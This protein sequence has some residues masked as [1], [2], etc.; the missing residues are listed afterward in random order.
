MVEVLHYLTI[1]TLFMGL[2]FVQGGTKGFGLGKIVFWVFIGP[3]MFSA[4]SE[5]QLISSAIGYVGG[6]WY[7]RSSPVYFLESFVYRL[8]ERWKQKF[9]S[10]SDGSPEFEQRD[11][12]SQQHEQARKRSEEAAKERQRQSKEDQ[13]SSNTQDNSD[14]SGQYSRTEAEYEEMKK[15]ARRAQEEAKRVRE[16]ADRIKAETDIISNNDNR[17]AEEV[18][19]LSPGFSKEDLRQAYKRESARFHENKW[20]KKPPDVQ[21]AMQEEL[22]KINWARDILDKKIM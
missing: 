11:D 2:G 4:L 5:I 8:K 22:K 3:S 17:S 7:S 15:Q 13:A 20:V 21:K 12:F 6:F 19:G 14:S 1:A 18:L 10:R 16:E 9:Q